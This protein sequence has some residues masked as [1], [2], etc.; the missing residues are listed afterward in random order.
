[1]LG[2]Q[3]V[4]LKLQQNWSKI[5]KSNE[6][7]QIVLSDIEPNARFNS[8]LKKLKKLVHIWF[9]GYRFWTHFFTKK[10]VRIISKLLEFV[11]CFGLQGVLCNKIIIIVN[12]KGRKENRFPIIIMNVKSLQQKNVWWMFGFLSIE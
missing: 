8:F 11:Q 9:I 4:H 2:E 3:T 7:H 10:K 12:A 6:N 1:M 5:E